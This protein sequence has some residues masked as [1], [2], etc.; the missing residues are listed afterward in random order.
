MQF[1]T[2]ALAIGS[3]SAFQFLV[4]FQGVKFH[5]TGQFEVSWATQTASDPASVYFLLKCTTCDT[6]LFG[7]KKILGKVDLSVRTA[8]FDGSNFMVGPGNYVIE[9]YVK[10]PSINPA[11]QPNGPKPLATSAE[12]EVRAP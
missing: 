1:S 11:P 9:V 2:L 5:T 8:N 7:S 4:P 3:V 12:F 10:K 6:Q